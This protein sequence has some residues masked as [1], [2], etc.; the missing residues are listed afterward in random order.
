MIAAQA[1]HAK[2]RNLALRKS[3]HAN[4]FRC[5]ADFN[6][7]LRSARI[8]PQLAFS[9]ASSGTSLDHAR[10]QPRRARVFSLFLSLFAGNLRWICSRWDNYWGRTKICRSAA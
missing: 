3:H 5:T 9:Q 1:R 7:L 8:C 4:V 6:S 2:A 10:D